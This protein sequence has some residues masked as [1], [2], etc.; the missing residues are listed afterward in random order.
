[1]PR[2]LTQA[3]VIAQPDGGGMPIKISQL[4]PTPRYRPGEQNHFHD[5]PIT[6]LS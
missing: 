1:M 6:I 3:R 5:K 2:A 4:M